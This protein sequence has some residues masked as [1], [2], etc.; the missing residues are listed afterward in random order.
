LNIKKKAEKFKF[1]AEQVSHHPPIGVCY[2][3]TPDFQ[4]WMEFG[5]KTKFGGNS[6]ACQNMG[7]C[8][9]ILKK[10]GHYYYWDQI[11]T[12][13]HNIIVGTMWLDHFGETEIVN[14][15]TGEVAKID[16]RK[17]GWFSKGRY[18]VKAWILDSGGKT[19]IA[20]DGK[21]DSSLY[22]NVVSGEPLKNHDPKVPIWTQTIKADPGNKWGMSKYA[23][24]LGEVGEDQD[25]PPTDSR[26]RQDIYWLA[27]GDLKKAG[28]EK[29]KIEEYQRLLR[30]KEKLKMSLG[31]HVILH[32][33]KMEKN[34]N[35]FSTIHIGK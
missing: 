17:C 26:L 27:R 25:L 10:T 16:F 12:M 33:K 29:R 23:M 19:R 9:L 2:C 21:W 24:Q 8:H 32:I 4:F 18:E 22:G 20:V 1:V 30:K 28:N 34:I 5:V 6:L 11:K 35:G 7:R 14:Q 31:F 15:S 3:E 13:V